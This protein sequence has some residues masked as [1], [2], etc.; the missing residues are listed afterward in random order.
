MNYLLAVLSEYHICELH[1]MKE[2]KGWMDGW[3]DRQINRQKGCCPIQEWQATGTLV[4]IFGQ[5]WKN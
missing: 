1:R 5:E 2:R 4:N 3:V